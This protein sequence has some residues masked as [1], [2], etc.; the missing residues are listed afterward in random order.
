MISQIFQ[1]INFF[2]MIYF[3]FVDSI[4][5]GLYFVV[6]GYYFLIFAY[7]LIMR[8]R[9]SKKLYWLFFSLLFLILSISRGFFIIYYFYAPE[10]HSA[11]LIML[12]YRLALF[13]TW[14]AISCLM[15]MLGIFLFPP[16]GNLEKKSVDKTK[17]YIK[18]AVRLVLI[19]SPIV[20]GIVALTLPDRLL[21]D[22]EFLKQFFIFTSI[23][24]STIAGYPAGRFI[25]NLIFQPLFNFLV[26][27][28]FFYL[29]K[30]TFGV[31]RRSYLINGI[32]FLLYYIGRLSY[33][34]FGALNL[35][36]T[37]AILPPLIIL[38]SLLI[39]VIAN[40][41]EALK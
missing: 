23:E 10:T 11:I 20:I 14:I 26:P 38:L 4:E 34:I 15:G 22:V 27:I 41:F 37:Q 30:K 3:G 24:P 9:V 25:I 16:E 1:Q 17:E 36:H 8:F 7:F 5:L 28:M 18:Y 19:I 29:A 12:N 21:I 39:I 33:S 2:E 13:F 31:L 6:I 32:G 40:S 35:P